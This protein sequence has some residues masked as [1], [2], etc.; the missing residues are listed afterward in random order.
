MYHH[1]VARS[2]FEEALFK[3]AVFPVDDEDDSRAVRL[4]QMNEEELIDLDVLTLAIQDTFQIW[5]E[6][7]E[8][9]EREAREAASKTGTGGLFG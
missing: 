2:D 6:I 8:E 1:I 5:F 7:L 4:Y 9:R 3:I